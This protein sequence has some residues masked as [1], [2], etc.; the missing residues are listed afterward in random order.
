VECVFSVSRFKLLVPKEHVLISFSLAGVRTPATRALDGGKV[1]PLAEEILQY[2]RSKVQQHSVKI[3]VEVGAHA[4]DETCTTTARGN[5]ASR[6]CRVRGLMCVL[7]LPC[8]V[9]MAL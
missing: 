8:C 6:E 3:E 9:L 2:V 4:R 5:C 7:A 1:D